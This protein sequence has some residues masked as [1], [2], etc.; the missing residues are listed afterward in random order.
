MLQRIYFNTTIST[1]YTVEIPDGMTAWE[2]ARKLNNSVNFYL[3]RLGPDL[4]EAEW[5]D[6]D[7]DVDDWTDEVDITA[8]QVID[9]ITRG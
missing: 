1:A 3:D 6:I 8:E 5:G 9:W 7:V 2:V 4:N